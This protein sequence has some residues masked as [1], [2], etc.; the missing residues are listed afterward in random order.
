MQPRSDDE[1]SNSLCW[2]S[3]EREHFP[4][5]NKI[6]HPD[7]PRRTYKTAKIQTEMYGLYNWEPVTNGSRLNPARIVFYDKLT[8]VTIL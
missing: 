5:T 8:E 6:V 3:F 7:V 1:E 2:D 4:V